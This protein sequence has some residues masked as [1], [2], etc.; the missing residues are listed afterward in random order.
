MA[1]KLKTATF[2]NCISV[3]N[4]FTASEIDTLTEAAKVYAGDADPETKHYISAVKDIIKTLTRRKDAITKEM[5]SVAQIRTATETTPVKEEVPVENLSYAEF[6]ALGP[7][8]RVA[9]YSKIDGRFPELTDEAMAVAGSIA[10]DMAEQNNTGYLTEYA[11][12]MERA[13]Q[14]RIERI[15]AELKET[16]KEEKAAGSEEDKLLFDLIDLVEEA[17]DKESYERSLANL[18][19]YVFSTDTNDKKPLKRLGNKSRAQIAEEALN[20][21]PKSQEVLNAL[22]RFLNL[23][24]ADDPEYKVPAANKAGEWTPLFKAI[25]E[26]NL[27]HTATHKYGLT[28]LPGDFDVSQIPE[29]VSSAYKNLVPTVGARGSRGRFSIAD[30]D[31]TTGMVDQNGKPI[32]A[33]MDVGRVRLAVNRFVAGLLNRPTVHIYKNQADLKARNP[34]LYARAVAARPEGDFDTAF[35]VGYSFGRVG[36]V[37]PEVDETR[38]RII[39][40]AAGAVAMPSNLLKLFAGQKAVPTYEEFRKLFESVRD[41]VNQTILE[42]VNYGMVSGYFSGSQITK[43][44]DNAIGNIDADYAGL[45]WGIEQSAAYEGEDLYDMG[46]RNFYESKKGKVLDIVKRA[47]AAEIKAVSD[48]AIKATQAANKTKSLKKGTAQK[49]STR[50]T[51]EAMPEDDSA[52]VIIFSDRVMTESQLKFVLAHETVGHFG[53]RA[54]VPEGK[55]NTVLN[56]IYDS[57]DN[58]KAAVDA[59][60]AA[61]GKSKS[62]AIEEYLADMAGSLDTSIIAKFWNAVKNFLN[63]L[64]VKFADDAARYFINQSRR[65]VRNG[66]VGNV[67]SNATIARNIYDIESMN[68]PQGSGRFSDD[69]TSYARSNWAFGTRGQAANYDPYESLDY[70]RR[71]QLSGISFMDGFNRLVGELKLTNYAARENL[72]MGR[73]YTI[74]DDMTTQARKLVNTYNENMPNALHRAVNLG[75]YEFFGSTE[76]EIKTGGLIFIDNSLSKFNIFEGQ[77]A[78]KLPSLIDFSTG[79]AKINTKNFEALKA[80]GKFT[81]KEVQEGVTYKVEIPVEMSEADKNRLRA[82]RDQLVAAAKNAREAANI[83]KDYDAQIERGVVYRTEERKTQARPEITKDSKEWIIYNEMFDQMAQAHLDKLVSQ[84]AKIEGQFDQ[85]FSRITSIVGRELTEGDRLLVR[86]I[87]DKYLELRNAGAKR[88]SN[89]SLDPTQKGLDKSNAFIATVNA[90]FVGR[91]T[92]RIDTAGIPMNGELTPPVIDYFPQEQRAEIRRA[93]LDF[94]KNNVLQSLSETDQDRYRIQHE[95]LNLADMELVKDT[96][97]INAKRLIASGYVPLTR[98]GKWQV[99]VQ[100]VDENGTIYKVDPEFQKFFDYEQTEQKGDAILTADFYNNTFA[101]Q[102]FRIRVLDDGKYVFKTVSLRATYETVQQTRADPGNM[103]VNEF[104]RLITQYGV[105]LR[106]EKRE[107]LQKALTSQNDRARKRF[108]RENQPGYDLDT[109]R[110]VSE[111]L[112]AAASIV[113]RNTHIHKLDAVFDTSLDA[114]MKL[115]RG[116]ENQYN[117]LKDAWERAQKDPAMPEAE[118]MRI[119]REFNDYHYTFV[120]NDSQKLGASYLDRARRLVAFVNSQRDIALSEFATGETSSK[121]RNMTVMAQLGFSIANGLLNLVSV[122][123]NVFPYLATYNDKTAFG[124]GFGFGK[125]AIA[126][127]QAASAVGGP[128]KNTATYYQKLLDDPA[129]LSASGISSYEAEFLRDYI[130][131]GRGD[132]S[133]T[134]SLMATTRGRAKSGTFQRFTELFMA[135]FSI[136][137]QMSRRTAG[138]AAFRL[139]F[140]RAQAEAEVA[141]RVFDAKQASKDAAKFAFHTTDNTLGQYANFGMPALFR[142]GWQQFLFMYK[143]FP[144]TTGL[145]LS[146]L[147]RT[148]KLVLIGTLV[149]FAGMRGIP[150]AEDLLDIIDTIAQRLLGITAGSAEAWVYREAEKIVPGLGGILARGMDQFLPVT[151]SSKMQSGNIIPGTSIMLPGVDTGREI[152]EVIGPVASVVEQSIATANNIAKYGL[153]TIGVRPDTTTLA[154]IVRE[155]PVAFFRAVGDAASYASNGA[156]LNANGYV[157]SDD[158]S[159]ATVIGR[160]MSFYPSSA[161]RENDVVRLSTRIRNYQRDV[162]VEFRNKWVRAKTEGDTARMR[163]IEQMVRDWNESASYYETGTEINNFVRNANRA[164]RTSQLS[165]SARG[166][167]ALARTTRPVGEELVD[168][169]ALEE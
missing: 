150:Y 67:F 105:P 143:V 162:S 2:S 48:L 74:L 149:M 157:V 4:Q 125:A 127:S 65:Y 131:S 134:N 165:G 22:V 83:T 154:Q 63:K 159:M 29:L 23:Q 110:S 146:N 136:T 113:A 77:D 151:L 96:E 87:R 26:A 99:R 30:Y 139:Y 52:V 71:M 33:P 68:D 101:D 148:G 97:E 81:L 117:A 32:K 7:K 102:K 119:K 17:K 49:E 79:T 27:F 43:T 121:I 28:T 123:T 141:G 89:G 25:L 54:I 145:L 1:K 98:R 46:L 92:D 11:A 76:E 56:S 147:D 50:R 130:L 39:K 62:E 166:L 44:I 107:Q 129:L 111:F 34:E 18:M 158:V 103:N 93:I 106:P 20:S 40:G 126:L 153:E 161:T 84:Y 42:D 64:G 108:K 124:G 9:E 31:S 5:V 57:H 120:T 133:A 72:G 90:A 55:L 21:Q 59:D 70:V 66:N 12:A 168:I 156:I 116:D 85:V 53:F 137:E 88:L 16:E 10:R 144:V 155:N 38:R 45:I 164:Y 51:A 128:S 6:M 69:R 82:K 36:T 8:V 91:D 109:L 37:R 14:E 73:V 58:I 78:K 13:E 35:A 47:A 61:N 86:L 135:P 167:K 163:E 118:R 142:G 138:L 132:A 80:M 95:I 94:R 15:R 112:E 104:M 160:L 140:D 41:A 24:I 75:G 114:S 100:A 122:G 115:W 3:T 19:E 60:I 169:L 152:K